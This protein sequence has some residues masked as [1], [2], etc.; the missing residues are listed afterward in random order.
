MRKTTITR[1]VDRLLVKR[2]NTLFEKA[3]LQG[4]RIAQP[5][6]VKQRTASLRDLLLKRRVAIISVSDT[7]R[8]LFRRLQGGDYWAQYE[9]TKALGELGYLVTNFE[10]DVVIHLFGAP[11]ELPATAFKIAWIYSHP[12]RVTPEVLSQYDRI[13]CLSSRFTHKIRDMG[14]NAE[15]APGATARTPRSNRIKYDVVF[16]GNTRSR[17]GGSRQIIMDLE[18]TP[19]NLKVWGKGWHKVL[20][21]RYFSGEYIDYGDL[22][23][24]YSSALVSL[25]DHSPEM[26]REGFVSLRIFDILGSGGFCISDDNAGIKEVF[27]EAVPQYQSPNELR[28]LIDFHIQNPDERLKLV[29]RGQNI[30]LSHSWCKRASQFMRGIDVTF[31]GQLG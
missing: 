15:W 19:Y 30:A 11:M 7:D 16:V 27:Q 5:E 28:E 1:Y 17:L 31:Q 9:L 18:G 14:F 6:R 23:E 26:S 25:S 29:Q 21:E 20:S 10:P 24:L 3:L 13:F 8:N 4:M 2:R 22:T 12:E